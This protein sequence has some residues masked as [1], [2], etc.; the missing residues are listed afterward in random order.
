MRSSALR[1]DVAIFAASLQALLPFTA[2]AGSTQT[3]SVR[4]CPAVVFSGTLPRTTIFLEPRCEMVTPVPSFRP[5]FGEPLAFPRTR[6]TLIRAPVPAIVAVTLSVSPCAATSG[7]FAVFVTVGFAA[8]AAG[9]MSTRR[10]A[11][12]SARNDLRDHF[13]APFATR[14][15]SLLKDGPV[16][17]TRTS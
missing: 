2:A 15:R 5:P 10:N 14:T 4:S 9:A 17:A 1:P 6:P 16:P 3:S 8:C 13:T 12:P 11:A 7:T